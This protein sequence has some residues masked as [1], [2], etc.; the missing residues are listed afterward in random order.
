MGAAAGYAR[1]S[2]SP[3]R[4]SRGD[5]RDLRAR[6]GSTAIRRG[7]RGMT[8]LVALARNPWARGLFVLA[9]LVL[10]ILAVWW[11]GP[12]WNTVY[13]AFDFVRWR[14]VIVAVLLNLS[15]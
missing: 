1:K 9:T 15:P 14:W 2:I 6:H 3:G 8:R 11:R 5:S 10:A 12:D 13:H 4:T 7:R